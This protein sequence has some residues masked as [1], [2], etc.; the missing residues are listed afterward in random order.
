MHMHAAAA[1]GASCA[2]MNE[3]M[4]KNENWLQSVAAAGILRKRKRTRHKITNRLLCLVGG[5]RSLIGK[6]R[7]LSCGTNAHDVTRF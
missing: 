3:N 2:D 1:A 5:L 7:Q 6:I 4:L